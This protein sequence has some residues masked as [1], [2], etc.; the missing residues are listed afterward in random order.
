MSISDTKLVTATQLD[1]FWHFRLFIYYFLQTNEHDSHV[2]AS[3]KKLITE[4]HNK[5]DC[6]SVTML[7]IENSPLN[8]I[9]ILK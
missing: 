5:D 1:K 3:T 6:S 4:I 2:S 7:F 9:F 8:A